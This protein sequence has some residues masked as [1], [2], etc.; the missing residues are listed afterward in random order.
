M[1]REVWLRWTLAACLTGFVADMIAI[2]AY[3]NEPM[4]AGIFDYVTFVAIIALI[5]FGIAAYNAPKENQ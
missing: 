5:V 2:F 1:T 4:P 3:E